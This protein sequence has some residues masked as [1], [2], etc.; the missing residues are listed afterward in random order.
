MSARGCPERSERQ[1]TPR[2]QSQPVATHQVSRQGRQTIKLAFG[3]TIFNGHVLPF[4]EIR[5]G[6]ALPERRGQMVE[7]IARSAM[8]KPDHR[9]CRLLRARGER[10]CRRQPAYSTEKF[11]PPHVR[12][13]AQEATS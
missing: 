10:P 1:E 13:Q 12:P 4:D 7:C 3:P 5:C 8:K 11:P 9:S 6:Q 2:N